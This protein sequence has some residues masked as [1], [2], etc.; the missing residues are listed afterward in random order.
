[1]PAHRDRS[2]TVGDGPALVNQ[3]P[4]RERRGS[5]SEVIAEPIDVDLLARFEQAALVCPQ[6]LGDRAEWNLPA[7]AVVFESMLAEKLV[8]YPAGNGPRDAAGCAAND[9]QQHLYAGARGL[10]C[11]VAGHSVLPLIE[12]TD[13]EPAGW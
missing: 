12:E 7:A 6:R 1:M 5:A 3:S 4:T 13:F 8:E 10:V 11:A 2:P 9:C